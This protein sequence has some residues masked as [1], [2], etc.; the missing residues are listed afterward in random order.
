VAVAVAPEPPV[1]VAEV[2]V[3]SRWPEPRADLRVKK[4]VIPEFP[5]AMVA[6]HGHA[7]VDCTAVVDIDP[8]GKP[9]RIAVVECPTGLHLEAVTALSR[10]RWEP[11]L[12]GDE[13]E[14]VTTTVEF[15]FQQSKPATQPGYTFLTDPSEVTSEL[16]APT[17]VLSGGLPVYPPAVQGGEASCRVDFVI[18]SSGASNYALV[19]GCAAPFRKATESAVK[20]W[21]FSVPRLDEGVEQVQFEVNIEFR[22]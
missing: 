8:K 10:W 16:S 12:N 11:F 3:E 6:M 19:D 17:L 4:R 1:A 9:E 2:P 13:P 18:L 15:G 7:P 5:S 20:S 22:K 21:K 14:G